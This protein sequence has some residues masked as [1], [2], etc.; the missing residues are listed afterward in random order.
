MVSCLDISYESCDSSHSRPPSMC[1]CTCNS[2]AL[3]F[4]VRTSVWRPTR[5]VCIFEKSLTGLPLMFYL[6]SHFSYVVFWLAVVRAVFFGGEKWTF[7][8]CV[9]RRSDNDRKRLWVNKLFARISFNNF[10]QFVK[11]LGKFD[12]IHA[13]SSRESQICNVDAKMKNK[14]DIRQIQRECGFVTK[15]HLLFELQIQ[16]TT[17][18]WKFVRIFCALKAFFPRLHPKKSAVVLS[19]PMWRCREN[20]FRK[21]QNSSLFSFMLT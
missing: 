13:E 16:H 17:I 15:N 18:W 1:L 7:H 5:V 14:H 21:T 3:D 12:C 20:V 4:R 10:I 9:W 2:N 6:H 11:I 19:F 8:S